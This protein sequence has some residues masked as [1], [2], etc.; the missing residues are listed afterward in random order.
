[1]RNLATTGP[2]L[3]TLDRHRQKLASRHVEITLTSHQFEHEQERHLWRCLDSTNAVAAL[4][5]RVRAV[6]P[7]HVHRLDEGTLAKCMVSERRASIAVDAAEHAIIRWAHA[8]AVQRVLCQ[9]R[10]EVRPARAGCGARKGL[11]VSD[12]SPHTFAIIPTTYTLPSSPFRI[13]VPLGV[14]A[15]KSWV[16]QEFACILRAGFGQRRRVSGQV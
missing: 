4:D 16:A 8:L 2:S 15:N 12:G 14:R 3:T 11:V 7:I 5:K 9:A 1:M 6:A 13:F 10:L